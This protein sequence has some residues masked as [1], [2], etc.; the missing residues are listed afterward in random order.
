MMRLPFQ[1]GHIFCPPLFPGLRYDDIVEASGCC[2]QEYIQQKQKRCSFILLGQ[3]WQ[4]GSVLDWNAEGC[5]VVDGEENRCQISKVSDFKANIST[6][7]FACLM[8]KW[9][10]KEEYLCPWELLWQWILCMC[11]SLTLNN[12]SHHAPSIFF[13][14]APMVTDS[15]YNELLAEFHQPSKLGSVSTNTRISS[16]VCF[17]I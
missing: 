2:F 14:S 15:E 3:N 10:G 9:A 13:L 17:C 12:R 7:W 5:Q 8:M 11:I 1:I 16:F 6:F 4:I